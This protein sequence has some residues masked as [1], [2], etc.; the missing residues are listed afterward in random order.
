MKIYVVNKELSSAH[1]TNV[2]YFQGVMV[3]MRPVEM[4]NHF[5]QVNAMNTCN[6]ILH[7]LHVIIYYNYFY[8]L[9]C[10]FK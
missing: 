2:L 5:S 3:Y 7:I 6:Y 4:N 8:L 1:G 9:S 10:R